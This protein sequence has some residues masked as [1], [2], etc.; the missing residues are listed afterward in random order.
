MS[1]YNSPRW[2][3]FV[4]TLTALF[5]ASNHIIGRAVH[6]Q[7][8]PIGLSFWR[9]V[10]GIVMFLPIVLPHIR[11]QWPLILQSWKL[12]S[13]LGFY[14]VGAT[15]LVLI[16][17]NH[18]FAV[19]VSM[20]NAVQPTLTVFFAW[21]IFRER[22]SVFRLLGIALGII[23][24]VTM[25]SRGQLSVLLAMDFQKGDFMAL[26]AMSGF[27]GYALTLNRLPKELSAMSALFGI[28]TMGTILLL[29]FYLWETIT[30]KPVPFN[31]TTVAAILA[32]ALLVSVLA[33]L[34]WYAGNRIIGPTRAS[35]F[36]NL[37][38]VFGAVLAILFLDEKLFSYHLVG[39]TLVILGL[40]LASGIVT[41]KR[42][43]GPVNTN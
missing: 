9:W 28:I 34:G 11:R 6:G 30:V 38:P 8:P 20:L 43:L 37:I 3:Y 26:V 22:L 35:I 29:P 31:S 18:T 32:L 40:V 36:V 12:L 10:A 25:I 24:V 42:K 41:G 2:A 7:V 33:N 39:G 19:N 4:L 17:L 5:L 16:A 15:T 21:L 27:A 1:K 14:I 23:G 13:L